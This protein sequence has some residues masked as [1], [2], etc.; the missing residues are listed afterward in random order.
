MQKEKV[1][2]DRFPRLTIDKICEEGCINVLQAFCAQ[3]ANEF[4]SALDQF[5]K[6]KSDP[7]L[8]DHYKKMKDYFCSEYFGLLTNL[9]GPAIVSAIE[10]E[11]V[12]NY[13]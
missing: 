13:M 6:N 12:E 11:Y 2:V 4:R 9:D 3:L 5:M 8:F 7:E 1:R 10:R